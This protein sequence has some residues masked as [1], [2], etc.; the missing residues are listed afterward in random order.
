MT[1]I[2]AVGDIQLGD[3]AICPGFGVGTWLAKG[4]QNGLF[5]AIAADLR[6]DLTVGNL[7]TCLSHA[8][9]DPSDWRS[10][11][12]RGRPESAGEL[13]DA[14]FD[15][16]NVANNH[17][18]QHGQRAFSET[19]QGLRGAGVAVCG[20]RGTDGWSSQPV[21]TAPG[22]STVG[23]LGYS[24]RPRQFSSAT[25][26]Y[27]EG[28]PEGMLRDIERLSA[29]VDHVIVTLHWGEEFVER[30]SLEEVRLARGMVEAGARIVAGH[31]PHV[32]RP[33]ESHQ[34]GVIAYSLGNLVGDM[35]WWDPLVRG[36]ILRCR[37]ESPR[38]VDVVRTEIGADLVPRPLG[39]SAPSLEP[40]TG[41]DPDAYHRAIARSQRAQRLASYRFALKNLRRY[42]RHLLRQL[43]FVTVR[44]KLAQL[45]GRA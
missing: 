16:V 8:G 2:V 24:M 18:F 7:E 26:P 33:I 20:L 30:P 29:E 37:L 40:V 38:M 5:S 13:R 6:G 15:V 43:A 35:V 31:H 32:L 21:R 25:P 36:A 4:A 12:M 39:R 17:T 34:G 42:P 22:D 28:T 1:T 14:G 44:N 45:L 11:Q 27:A 41:L 23:I 10:V 9:L 19:V 3:S